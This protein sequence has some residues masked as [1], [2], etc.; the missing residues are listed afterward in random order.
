MAK[1]SIDPTVA[2]PDQPGEPGAETVQQA[3]ADLFQPD[4][5]F[6]FPLYTPATLVPDWDEDR[7]LER[8]REMMAICFDQTITEE[9]KAEKRSGLASQQLGIEVRHALRLLLG[10][11]DDPERLV[12]H[13]RRCLE[14]LSDLHGRLVRLCDMDGIAQSVI[15]D[16]LDMTPVKVCR[17][18]HMARQLLRDCVERREAE[19]GKVRP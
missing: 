15:A 8:Q 7:M 18:L 9:R 1:Q 3:M 17:H 10:Y 12:A 5:D 6:Y 2:V 4:E 11:G 16:R 14:E 13:L 19:A